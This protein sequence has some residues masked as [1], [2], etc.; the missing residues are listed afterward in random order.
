MAGFG[1]ATPQFPQQMPDQSQGTSTPAHAHGQQGE[2]YMQPQTTPQDAQMGNFNHPSFAPQMAPQHQ[3]QHHNMMMNHSNYA[4]E[5]AFGMDH[6]SGLSQVRPG[7][8][9]SFPCTVW[10][11][12]KQG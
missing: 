2:L 10:E 5:A 6:T 12:S 4:S 8:V 3:Q 9:F 1:G 11:M 7:C